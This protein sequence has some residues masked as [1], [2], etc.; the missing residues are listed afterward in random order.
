MKKL[1]LTIRVLIVILAVQAVLFVMLAIANLDGMRREIATETR[2]ATQTARS[3]VLAT[4][5]T[6]Q[7][8]VPDDRLMAM[9]PERLVP[10]RHTR[11]AILDASDGTIRQVGHTGPRNQAAPPWF[12]RLLAPDPTETR[13][14]VMLRDR[15]R[16]FVH[17]ATDSGDEIASAWRDIGKTLGLAALASAVQALLIL[18]AVRAAL[19]PVATITA[20][21]SEMSQGDLGA[22]V[23]PLPQPDLAPLAEGVDH[24]AA[25][26]EQARA[27]RSR[28]QRQVVSRAD[29][30]RKA[31]AR[32]LHDEM[33]P[34]L[35]GLRVEAEA[36]QDRSRTNDDRQSAGAIMAIADQIAGVN[37]ALLNDLRPAAIGQLPL[38]DVLRDYVGDLNRMATETR[39]ELNIAPDLPEPDEP[40]AITL[41]RILQ[42]G[43][44]N[45]LRHAH[46]DRITIR[47]WTD[48]AHW[49]MILTDDG[50][51][52]PR[53]YRPGTGLTGMRERITLLGG[54]LHLSS[55]GTGTTIDATLPRRQVK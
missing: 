31:I 15:L 36:L 22:R 52:L 13:L 4:I 50:H 26:L 25:S 21:L 30:E 44:T 16:G 24:L 34:C 40:T 1:S 27:E 2:L 55:E 33:G 20:R 46:P 29:D 17:I 41:F 9:L 49:R 10:P 51:G 32:D 7:G 6:M 35:F 37:R 8:S 45:A 48:P 47:V 53:Q 5:G 38:A 11:I 12:S 3:L 43:C 28:L 23:G 42:E 39:I 19:R 14:P 18:F 54:S